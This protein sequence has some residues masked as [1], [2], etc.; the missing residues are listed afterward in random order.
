MMNIEFQL[1]KFFVVF[2]GIFNHHCFNNPHPFYQ[3]REL[4]ESGEHIH[5]NPEFI[6]FRLKQP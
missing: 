6:G 1:I 2:K 5:A 4:M 3:Q